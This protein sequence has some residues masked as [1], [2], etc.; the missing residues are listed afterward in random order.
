MSELKPCPL[1]GADAEAYNTT[2]GCTVACSNGDC[3]ELQMSDWTMSKAVSL[4][5]TRTPQ[6]E[7][8]SVEKF[9]TDKDCL[10]FAYCN[11]I[12]NGW[13]D[14]LIFTPDNELYYPHGARF[15][16]IVTHIQR[17]DKPT[18]PKQ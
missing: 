14:H 7:W 13:V 6:S 10:V 16:A 4:W 2:K 18:P 3:V 15:P 12:V 1:C 9:K 8:V 11:D 17:I 5:N